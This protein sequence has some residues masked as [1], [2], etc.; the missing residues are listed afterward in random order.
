MRQ[1]KVMGYMPLEGDPAAETNGGS[2]ISIMEP[3]LSV[4]DPVVDPALEVADPLVETNYPIPDDIAADLNQPLPDQTIP[5]QLESSLAPQTTLP[6]TDQ[7]ATSAVNWKLI[8]A[9]LVVGYLLTRKS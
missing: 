8:I 6:T 7:P 1:R 3:Q 9:L 4:S 5:A 2:S